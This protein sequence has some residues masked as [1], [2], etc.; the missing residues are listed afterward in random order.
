MGRRIEDI[1][2]PA[3]ANIGAIVRNNQVV[4]AHDDVVVEADD[5][6]V[7]FLVDK[8]RIRE[9]EKLFHAPLTFA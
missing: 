2:L 5:H 4:I 6:V 3:G 9:I 7:L 1:E 8:K